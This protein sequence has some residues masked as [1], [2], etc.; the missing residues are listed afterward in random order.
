MALAYAVSSF[1]QRNM[2]DYSLD[3][4]TKQGDTRSN[5]SILTERRKGKAVETGI[6]ATGR[7]GA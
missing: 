2:R 7:K 3:L 6:P 4:I 1:A 5:Q